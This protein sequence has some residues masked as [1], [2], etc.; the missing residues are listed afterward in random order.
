MV[1]FVSFSCGDIF[2]LREYLKGQKKTEE[3]PGA[4]DGR[5][6][7][8]CDYTSE[9]VCHVTAHERTHTRVKPYVCRVC[10]REFTVKGNL[11]RHM[12]AVHE[13]QRNYKCPACGK[14]FQQK[15]HLQKHERMHRSSFR[16]DPFFCLAGND[17]GRAALP[18]QSSSPAL[19]ERWNAESRKKL[20]RGRPRAGPAEDGPHVCEV[21]SKRF[22]GKHNLGRH[23]KTVH[24]GEREHECPVCGYAFQHK[25]NLQ[26][27]LKLHRD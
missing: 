7:R 25:H 12:K 16:A 4:E 10:S 18:F 9:N 11:D 26:R 5:Q 13:N 14:A 23:L 17:E 15:S 21:C 24:G 27:H 3:Y 8:Y 20:R 1:P 19:E 2:N 6:C 22:S